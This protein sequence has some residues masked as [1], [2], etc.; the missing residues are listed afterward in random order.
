MSE[1]NSLAGW[2]VWCVGGGKRRLLPLAVFL[3]LECAY[4]LPMLW[5]WHLV[6]FHFFPPRFTGI[7]YQRHL[8]EGLRWFPSGDATGVVMDYP[9]EFYTAQ[10]LRAGELPWWNPAIGCGRAWIG[11]AQVFP[12]SPLL[13]PYV[14]LP[15][16]WTYSLQFVLGSLVCLI[17]AYWL[18]R[19]MELE[20]QLALFGSALWSF[21]YFTNNCLTMAAV[22]AY[23]WL[24]LACAG[25]LHAIR[26]K[27]PWG[28]LA[29]AAALALMVLCGHSETAVFLW[30]MVLVFAVCAWFGHRAKAG[31]RFVCFGLLGMFGLAALMSAAQWFPVLEV[32]KDAA[33]Y[34][35]HGVPSENITPIFHYIFH[36]GRVGPVV[37]GCAL[38]LVARR[39]RW[40]SIAFFVMLLF[41]LGFAV[42][43]V[44]GSIVYK[45][46]T[47]GG[48]VPSV[49]GSELVVAPAAAL[50]AIGLQRL[51]RLR[52]EGAPERPVRWLSAAGA[53]ALTAVGEG[54]LFPWGPGRWTVGL[55]IL[56]A[57][58][59]FLPLLFL[60]L[61]DSQL[62]RLTAG[63]F[64]AL[65]LQPLVQHRFCY[66]GFGGD[67]QPDWRPLL[68]PPDAGSDTPPARIWAQSS[69]GAGLPYLIPN[70]A[71]LAGYQD[72][73]SSQVLNTPG[74]DLFEPGE[75]TY[76]FYI[77]FRYAEAT[78][79]LLSFLGVD[80]AA[81]RS[82]QPQKLFN[83]ASIRPGPRAFFVR[84]FARC[85]DERAALSAFRDIF[86]TGK[87]YERA[88]VLSGPPAGG[89]EASAPSA[90]SG[91]AGEVSWLAYEPER[92]KL[93]VTARSPGLLV[94]LESVN[95]LWKATVDGVPADL[96]RADVMFRGVEVPA[97][98]HVVEMTYDA[99]WMRVSVWICLAVW[100]AA[101]IFS[102][103]AFCRRPGRS[104]GA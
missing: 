49:H 72:V 23:W 91:V 92:V 73:R 100:L 90:Q 12:F 30:E 6:S 2:R 97:G 103:A 50:A 22:W 44:Y 36:P 1:G 59:L 13:L 94:V 52:Q 51:R 77:F 80:R 28:W 56:M 47:L 81:T 96:L 18:F 4:F 101:A 89:A 20:P 29:G 76:L 57:L 84:E 42:E 37:W 82:D 99:L 98:R 95:R 75:K 66:P 61:S 63:L 14:L 65:A 39:P 87:A 27:S 3:A 104:R 68:G 5:G 11:N 38:L 60:P 17:G 53:L 43:P 34:K 35:S 26:R 102:A 8:P 93:A 55:W 10:R 48:M 33:W 64:L 7:S 62:R 45:A 78:P 24:P 58:A 70:L 40:D 71:L 46:V 21:N 16:P 54:L 15:S 88:V 32:L 9:N 69:P 31:I 25:V 83:V 79:Q 41:A 85:G 74:S 86:R 19:Q 67:P